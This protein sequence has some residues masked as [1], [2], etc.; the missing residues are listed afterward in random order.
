M[1]ER[2]LIRGEKAAF[3][4]AFRIVVAE[5]NRS[6]QSMPERST[7][8]SP[9][10]SASVSLQHTLHYALQSIPRG[11]SIFRDHETIE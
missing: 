6:V 2:R 1:V 8:H 5:R 4:S 3:L 7:D 11:H 9:I 10:S